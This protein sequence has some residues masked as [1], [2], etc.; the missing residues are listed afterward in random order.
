MQIEYITRPET[1]EKFRAEITS[2]PVIGV[3]TETTELDPLAAEL[4]LLQISPNP[5]RAFVFDVRALREQGS[6]NWLD[7]VW[8]DRNKVKIFHNAKFDI[9]FLKS[10]L[11][12]GAFECVYDTYLASVLINC[13]EDNVGNSL[14]D[15]A[16]RYG[17]F[18][19][20]KTNQ[21]SDFSGELSEE[22]IVYAARDAAV[23]HSVRDGENKFIKAGQLER[24]CTLEFNAVE[25]VAQMELN[26]IYLRADNW[27]TRLE[28]QEAQLKDLT[29]RLD[30]FFKPV[31]QVSIFG[32]VDLNYDSPEPV[33]VALK[34]LGVPLEDTT[35][36]PKI[37]H[38]AKDW[39]VIQALLDY[40]EVTT[41]LKM[42]GREYLNFIHPFDQRIHADFRQIGTPTGRFTCGNPNLQQIPQEGLYRNDF[43]AQGDDRRLVIADYSQIE[44]RILAHF[45]RDEKM[46]EAFVQNKDLH[47]QTAAGVFKV[48]FE[49]IGKD[50]KE[51]GVGKF[52]NF[53]TAYGTGKR[54]F[55]ELSGLSEKESGEALEAFWKLYKGLDTYLRE[56][57]ARAQDELETHSHSG[58]TWRFDADPA[59][60]AAMATIG[61]LGRNFPV[62]ATCSDIVKRA[63]YLANNS[64]RG[65]SGRIVNVIHDELVAECSAAEQ[66][67]V[68]GLLTD[69]MQK[70]AEEVITTVPVVIDSQISPIWKK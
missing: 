1:V 70:A 25:S 8:S 52:L 7:D 12:A 54:R 47:K 23:L 16:P 41:A 32:D 53:S 14:K 34:R 26:G 61:R 15:V 64:L 20:D 55:A 48:D 69:A 6:L 60:H 30:E 13:G 45:S 46:T 56:A 21:R 10:R 35:L 18:E 9:E 51:R 4:R 17:G 43:A 40:R 5:E 42:F 50:S 67:T 65:T 3:D 68:A 2:A 49:T 36:E 38:L 63:L 62:Q 27:R 58:R 28:G 31:C 59:D 37:K 19:L 57:E 24:V 66:E 33:L 29:A 44:L 22:Q 11:G 39:P